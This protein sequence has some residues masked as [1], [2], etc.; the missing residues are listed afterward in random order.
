MQKKKMPLYGIR[1]A[2]D[3]DMKRMPIEMDKKWQT[4][5][6]ALGTRTTEQ[7]YAGEHNGVSRIAVCD[8]YASIAKGKNVIASRLC[9]TD[10]YGVVI[11]LKENSLGFP[12]LMSDAAAYRM[13]REVEDGL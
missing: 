10:V 9:G 7:H 12:V 3:G 1:I 5:Q 6:S 4:I 8:R 13:Q 2:V 11:L